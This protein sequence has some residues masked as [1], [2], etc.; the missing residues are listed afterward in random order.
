MGE[1]EE[2][3]KR[4]IFLPIENTRHSRSLN[5]Y[6]WSCM[7]MN[8][9][10]INF[11]GLSNLNKVQKPA[12][13]K[14]VQQDERGSLDFHILRITATGQNS[15]YNAEWYI[16]VSVTSYMQTIRRQEQEDEEKE[17]EEE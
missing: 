14:P 4:L 5:L 11:S 6:F 10:V 8:N 2:K 12:H 3:T 15:T 7:Q 16:T 17:E 1:E 9:G 13:A